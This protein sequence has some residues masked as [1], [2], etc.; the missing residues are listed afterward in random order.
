LHTVNK[1][2]WSTLGYILLVIVWCFAMYLILIRPPQQAQAAPPGTP[3]TR[4]NKLLD[5]ME[6]VESGGQP[7]AVGDAGRSRGPLQIQEPYWRDAFKSGKP[8]WEYRTNV[9]DRG[10][11]RE[12][13]KMYWKRYAPEAYRR[14]DVETLARIHNGGPKGHRKTATKPY[15]TKV[16]SKMR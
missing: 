9:W 15:W 7:R 2:K 13:T 1:G 16:Q 12:V 10:K 4:I 3:T 6:R 14:G 11:S 5:A 8:K